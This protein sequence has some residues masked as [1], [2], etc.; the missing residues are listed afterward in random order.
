[1]TFGSKRGTKNLKDSGSQSLGHTRNA[2][3]AL[4]TMDVAGQFIGKDRS[5]GMKGTLTDVIYN[6]KYNFNLV[7]LTRLLMDDWKVTTGDN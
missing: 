7:S 3:E 2:V 4:N 6:D 1:M 5:A